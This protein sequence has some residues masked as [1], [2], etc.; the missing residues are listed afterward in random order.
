MICMKFIFPDFIAGLDSVTSSRFTGKRSVLRRGYVLPDFTTCLWSST[1]SRFVGERSALRR[2]YVLPDF[3]T[4]L[5]SS[6]S[7]RF[8]GERSA[9]RRGYVLPDFTTCLWSTTSLRFVDGLHSY[10]VY[11]GEYL[12]HKKRQALRPA[13]FGMGSL[14]DASSVAVFELLAAAA[15]AWVVASGH[16]VFDDGRVSPCFGS[17]ACV[18]SC[19]GGLCGVAEIVFT[20][21]V[22]L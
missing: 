19:G 10:G 14:D 22:S 1:S 3:T 13:V 6:T 7:S 12:W 15:G 2:G 5:W 9:L 11:A 16:L 4:C 18:L 21:G 8:V 20:F 17:L